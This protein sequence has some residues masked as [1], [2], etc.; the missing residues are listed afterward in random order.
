MKKY[1]ILSLSALFLTVGALSQSQKTDLR[2]TETKVADLLMKLPPQNSADLDK[3]MAELASLGEPAV[4]GIAANLVS[5]GKGNDAASRYALSGLVKYVSRGT[6]S[7]LMKSTSL[8]LCKSLENAKDEEVKDF[9]L[10]ELQFVAGD[11]AVPA[12]SSFLSDRRLCDPAARVLIRINTNASNKA[13]TEA[14]SKA[15]LPQK[16]VIAEALGYT[17]YRPA[18]PELLQL[19]SASDV[20][21]K[22]TVLRALAE[23]GDPQ[24]ANLLSSEAKKAGY[25]FDPS[26]VTGSYLLFLKRTVENGNPS[27]AEKACKAVMK[28][29]KIHG[30][31][32]TGALQIL[33]LSAG[34]KAVPVLMKALKSP[35]KDYRMAAEALLGKSSSPEVPDGI[36]KLAGKTKNGELQAELITLLA[37]KSH[38]PSLPLMIKLLQSPDKRVQLSAIMAAAKTGQAEAVAPLIALLK[39]AGPETITAVKKALLTIPGAGVTDAAAAA[40]PGVS[41]ASRS[42]L[43]EIISQRKDD[44]YA[45]LIFAETGSSD[46]QTRLAALKAL[47]SLAKAGDEVKIADLMNRA[48]SAEEITL[49]QEALFASLQ[50]QPTISAQTEKLV[51]LMNAA[52]GKEAR[53]YRVFAGI[54]GK[55]ALS[56]VEK[57]LENG[58]PDDQEQAMQALCNWSD[59]SALEALYRISKNN[60]SGKYREMALNSFIGGINTSGNTTD[61]KVLMFRN[62]MDLTGNA[63]QKRQVLEGISHNPT[64]QSLAFV[65]RYLDDPALQQ[66]AVQAVNTILQS[67]TGLYG[68]IVENIAQKAISLNKDAEADYQ[69]QAILKKLASLPKDDGFV[70]LFN[71][72]DL[73]GWKGL[74]GNPLT[75]AKMSE[76]ALGEAQ[77]KTDAAA[78]ESWV[79]ENGILLFKGKGDNLCSV[80]EYGDFEMLVDWKLFPGKEPDAGIYLRGTPQVQIWDTSRVNVGAQVGSGGLYNNQQNISKPL[81]VADNAVGEWNTFRIRMIGD[82]VTVYLNGQ[83]VVDNVTL[84]N[85]WD[86]SQPIFA[87][88]PVELQAHGSVVGYRDIYLKEI[89]RPEP[90][91]LSDLEKQE[92]FVPLFNGIDLDGWT[93]NLTDYFPQEGMIVCQP[94]GHGSGNLYTA[95]EYADFILRFEFQLTPGANNGLGIRAPLTGDA[96]Y[97]GMELQ[98]LDNEADIY[99][100]LKPFQYHGS[101]YG[102]I[103]AKRG[104]LKPVGEWNLQEVQAIGNRIKVTL[105]GEVILDGDIAAA[106]NNNTETADHQKHP[107]LLNKT[108]HIGFLGH[109]SPLKFRNLR[110][111]EL[112]E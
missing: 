87:A 92:G 1:L 66:T 26:D 54:G 77:L 45:P 76:K 41:G 50:W 93:G 48:V 27:F 71:G 36:L 7:G 69:K 17:K 47:S 61:Q 10:Q 68:P 18:V 3:L 109:G 99:K 44:R 49:L 11:E 43:I 29:D 35:E 98:I 102:V 78:A 105:N 97:V 89:P 70:P 60:P 30:Y 2:T 63:G 74:V 53:Y 59:D 31:F 15:E 83:L 55:E 22:K 103:P 82:K 23:T 5:P 80:K 79:V 90:Y 9:L 20:K 28:D 46:Q 86:R 4:T 58:S 38:K 111:K 19:A 91:K 106:S 64:L 65:S 13:L 12:A 33:T 112:T 101:V 110:I 72:K 40:I 84:E 57:Q 8:A 24:A 108:G 25:T 81:I 16:I 14:L 100:N 56:V 34:Q 52:N 85:Y 67:S 51:N 32:R 107:G 73:T 39:T 62:A 37:A 94:T 88:G 21:L 104:Y 95:K 75:R 42:A 6:D 96:A